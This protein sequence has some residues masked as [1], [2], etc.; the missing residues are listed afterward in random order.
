MSDLVNVVE[1]LLCNNDSKRHAKSPTTTKAS[2][3]SHLP[4]EI[5]NKQEQPP[6]TYFF[7]H[8]I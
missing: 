3:A 2:P 7:A 5:K 8:C 6:Q 1:E 4:S